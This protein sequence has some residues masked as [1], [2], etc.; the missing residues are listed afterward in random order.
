MNPYFVPVGAMAA[1]T[2]P[3]IEEMRKYFEQYV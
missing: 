1:A 3:P 2:Q